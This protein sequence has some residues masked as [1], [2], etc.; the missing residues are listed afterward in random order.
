MGNESFLKNEWVVIEEA[1]NLTSYSLVLIEQFINQY[2]RA[3]VPPEIR[4]YVF[5]WGIIKEYRIDNSVI[6]HFHFLQ[7]LERIQTVGKRADDMVMTCLAYFDL[8]F[9]L[10]GDSFWGGDAG[11]WPQGNSIW[12]KGGRRPDIQSCRHKI[13]EYIGFFYGTETNSLSI[14]CFVEDESPARHWIG[15]VFLPL[16]LAEMLQLVEESLIRYGKR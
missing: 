3:D 1:G 6:W 14:E 5:G 11:I 10:G 16:I 9:W 8:D 12:E 15:N 7:L 4:G 13:P 2:N